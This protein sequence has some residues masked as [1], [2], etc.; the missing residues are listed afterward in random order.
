MCPLNGKDCV[1]DICAWYL[2]AVKSSSRQ[3][4]IGCSV[5]LLARTFSS[6]VDEVG[7]F[8]VDGGKG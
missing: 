2:N 5:A 3:G 7:D 4:F 8:C 6:V 1:E